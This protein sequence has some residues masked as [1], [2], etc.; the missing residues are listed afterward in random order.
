MLCVDGVVGERV[1]A[2]VT[3]V[4]PAMTD[5]P[6]SKQ[7][8][9]CCSRQM[10]SRA[11][12]DIPIRHCARAYHRQILMLLAQAYVQ[13]FGTNVESPDWV[14]HT[15]P[16]FPWGAPNHDTIYGFAPIDPRGTY[17]VSGTQG[18]ETIASLMFRKGGA[19]TGQ[20]HGATLGEIDVQSIATAH[21]SKV[22]P[23]DRCRAAGG[24][25]GPWHALPPET[26]GMVARHVTVETRAARWRVV[27]R[28]ARPQRACEPP[29]PIRRRRACGR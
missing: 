9:S 1:L 28:A 24:Y 16:L 7:S 22:Q 4:L 2:H 12:S 26:T 15:G 5:A 17:R 6:V 23:P 13:V 19:N 8:S 29:M 21:G 27:A 14:P 18:T 3:L 20:V 10:R 11:R 25:T